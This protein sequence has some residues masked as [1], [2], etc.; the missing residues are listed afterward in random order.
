MEDIDNKID[1]YTRM[2]EEN[3]ERRSREENKRQQR[4]CNQGRKSLLPEFLGLNKPMQA[5]I[6]Y[7]KSSIFEG[8]V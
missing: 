4:Q 8:L 1:N 6:M 2:N 7:E 3:S 5:R